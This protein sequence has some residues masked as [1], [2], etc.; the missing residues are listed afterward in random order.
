M[1]TSERP[2]AFFDISIGVQ[3]VGRI[4][5]SLYSDTV[6]KTAENFRMLLRGCVLFI[7]I[8]LV[9]NVRSAM[10]WRKGRRFFWETAAL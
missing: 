9:M 10:Y 4:A 2:I 7:L 5:F 6:P 8:T 3:S 1:T